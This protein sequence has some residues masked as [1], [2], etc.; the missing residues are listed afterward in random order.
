MKQGET[1]PASL[2]SPRSRAEGRGPE[3]RASA[4]RKEDDHSAGTGGCGCGL[5][6]QQPEESTEEQGILPGL[7]TEED[8]LCSHL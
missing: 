7:S 1:S 3:A 5:A 4:P 2:E 8:E 6:L